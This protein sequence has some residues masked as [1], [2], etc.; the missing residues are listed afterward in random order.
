MGGNGVGGPAGAGERRTGLGRRGLARQMSCRSGEGERGARREG[1]TRG[2]QGA[3]LSVCDPSARP[4][5]QKGLGQT[6]EGVG[7][8]GELMREGRLFDLYE[9][10]AT[11]PV[12]ALG[13]KQGERQ[14]RLY[15]VTGVQ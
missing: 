2:N 6:R 11:G 7:A 13:F 1:L 9:L 4:G 5:R 8:G 12:E 10:S 14:D 3:L 15:V